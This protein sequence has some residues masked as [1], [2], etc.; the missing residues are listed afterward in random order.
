[1]EGWKCQLR[2]TKRVH[3]CGV[4]SYTQALPVSETDVPRQISVGEC[5]HWVQ[6]QAVF[7]PHGGEHKVN[8]PGI[9][10]FKK[11][12]AGEEQISGGVMHCQGADTTVAGSFL[13]AVLVQEE[14][15]VTIE[16]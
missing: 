11:Q 6:R 2:V 3:Y 8:V 13:K 7:H 9:T 16:K 5:S 15:H 12:V 14:W 4:A 1:M 10:I